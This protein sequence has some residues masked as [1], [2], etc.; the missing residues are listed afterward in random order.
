MPAKKTAV[1]GG[2]FNPVHNGHIFLAQLLIN[3]TEY[4]RLIFIP[5]NKP[6]HKIE[7]VV[8]SAEH[9]VNMLQ[10]SIQDISSNE[11]EII[12]DDCEISRGGLSYSLDTVNYIYNTYEVDGKL[13]FI[14]GDDLAATLSTWYKWDIL[15]EKVTFL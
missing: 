14:I 5:V 4:S 7:E 9:R 12:L 2:T 15:K 8:M 1:I 6:S 10:M 13:G 11:K 3:E